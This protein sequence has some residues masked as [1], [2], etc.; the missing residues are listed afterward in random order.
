VIVDSGKNVHGRRVNSGV[1]TLIEIAPDGGV[2]TLAGPPA[3]R[4]DTGQ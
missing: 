1:R 2:R 3:L 4:E